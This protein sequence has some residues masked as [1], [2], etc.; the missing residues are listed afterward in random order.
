M[1]DDN[2]D[3]EPPWDER[4]GFIG[5]EWDGDFLLPE[6]W[7]FAEDFDWGEY[8]WLLEKAPDYG[9]RTIKVEA[10]AE[11]FEVE[12]DEGVHLRYVLPQ[13]PGLVILCGESE[14]PAAGTGHA[15]LLEE[16]RELSE[17][18]EILRSTVSALS[19][20]MEKL[21]SS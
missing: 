11:S 7:K 13:I 16:G 2:N 15:Y 20:D 9:Q 4:S 10:D 6:E 14:G 12:V 3:D 17:V 19:E 5:S 1:S 8:S 18:T 21:S